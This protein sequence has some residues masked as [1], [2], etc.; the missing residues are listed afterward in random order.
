MKY[1]HKDPFSVG[2][3][4]P[5][6]KCDIC[7]DTDKNFVKINGIRY[8]MRCLKDKEGTSASRK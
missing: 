3:S 5:D 1:L 2:P 6:M 7:K 8:C 4:R